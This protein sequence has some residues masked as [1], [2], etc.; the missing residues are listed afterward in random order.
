MGHGNFIKPCS[1]LLTPYPE[2]R[3]VKRKETNQKKKKVEAT[4]FIYLFIYFSTL[5]FFFN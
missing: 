3:K 2:K 4:P 5:Q 1:Q